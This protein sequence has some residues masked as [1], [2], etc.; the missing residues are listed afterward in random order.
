MLNINQKIQD[1][2]SEILSEIKNELTKKKDNKIVIDTKKD[3]VCVG[4]F[5][6]ASDSPVLTELFYNSKND[7][8]YITCVCW[9]NYK[10]PLIGDL[11]KEIETTNVGKIDYIDYI[12]I[13]K[14]FVNQANN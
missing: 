13:Y 4:S 14:A 8:V 6:N 2:V 3:R 12:N 11:N 7:K 1:L 10:I 5:K 9:I